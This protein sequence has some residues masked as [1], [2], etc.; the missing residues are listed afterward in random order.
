MNNFL[1]YLEDILP[2]II[3]QPI[4]SI[5]KTILHFI[6]SKSE[7]ERIIN[8]NNYNINI[9]KEFTKCILKSKQL[10]NIKNKLYNKIIIN[11]KDTLEEIIKIKKISNKKFL[12]I[13][14]IKLCLQSIHY[15]QIIYYEINKLKNEKFNWNNNLNYDLLNQFWI[16]MLPNQIRSSEQKCKDWGD[17]GFQGDDPSTD[18]RGMGLLGLHQLTYFATS[19]PTQAREI[20]NSSNHPRR[21]YPFAATGINITSFIF[22]LLNELRLQTKLYEVLENNRLNYSTTWDDNITNSDTNQLISLGIS[23]VNDIYCEIYIEFNRVWVEEDPEDIMQFQK[24]FNQ[25]KKHYREKYRLF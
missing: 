6:T 14:N 22:E 7:I 9:N 23:V 13:S 24:I 17:V 3:F 1:N 21:Y 15:T 16:L 4:K 18:F 12:I 20:L 19:Y 11:C 5:Y 25:V 10:K 8:N 2:S